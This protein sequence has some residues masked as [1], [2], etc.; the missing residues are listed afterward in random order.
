MGKRIL[1]VACVF[2]LLA[3]P[4]GFVVVDRAFPNVPTHPPPWPAEPSQPERL[5]SGLLTGHVV[6][7]AIVAL[8]VPALIRG[9]PHRLAAWIIIA[10]WLGVMGLATLAIVMGKT[11]KY[12]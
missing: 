6:A 12:L 7:S 11:G 8:A 1:W 9:W 5:T 10:V 4:F 2:A 3:V